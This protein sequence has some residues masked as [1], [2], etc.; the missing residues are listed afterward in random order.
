MS[1]RRRQRWRQ[2]TAACALM[3][4]P[5]LARAQDRSVVVPDLTK[6]ELHLLRTT[7]LSDE[8]FLTG[9]REGAAATIA[10]ELRLPPAAGT[11]RVPAVVLV[12]GSSG[13][14]AIEERWSRELLAMGIATLRI[15]GFAGR[16][17][18]RTANDQSQ[19]GMLAMI[20]DAYR[21]LD[22]LSRDARIDTSRIGLLG[23]SRG[24]RIA[25]YASLKRFQRMHAAPGAAFAVYF[26]FYAHCNATYVDDTDVADRPIRLF[27][28]TA[29][30]SA[31]IGPC[32]SYVER[33]RRA[34]KDVQLHEYEGAHH[35]FDFPGLPL[36]H[37]PQLQNPA[38][39]ALA[40]RPVGQMVNEET[41]RP[42][43]WGDACVTRGGTTA[44]DPLAHASA[45]AEVQATLR[46]VF[47]LGGR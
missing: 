36:R 5:A 2:I 42:F 27:H 12:H 40:E 18:R 38:A 37:A 32:R 28:G 9:V 31:R 47:M 15:D 10:A 39:C 23:G 4:L 1:C 43:S 17:I 8:Q 14:S 16:G 6:T 33:L 20:V 46:R 45:L 26:P 34:G 29:D 13:P 35:A 3:A 41:H 44:H 25:L 19:L 22:Y 21:A 7:T 11:E 24:G 30:D